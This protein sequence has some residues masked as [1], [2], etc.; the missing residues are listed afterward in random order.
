VIDTGFNGYLTL[1]PDLIPL[2]QLASAG[3]RQA[4][5]GD[6]ST[7][8]MNNYLATVS[9]HGSNREVLAL[10]SNGGPLIGMSL[11]HGSRLT[12]DVA[13]HGDVTIQELP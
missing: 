10:E 4:I 9:W 12:M 11:L 1:P 3:S 2:L 13:D 6:G 7:V 8:T 5:L